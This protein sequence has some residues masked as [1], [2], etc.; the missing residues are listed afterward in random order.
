MKPFT[1]S[2]RFSLSPDR[3][4][5][6]DPAAAELDLES[7]FKIGVSAEYILI[8]D[9]CPIAQI[10]PSEFSKLCKEMFRRNE[11]AMRNGK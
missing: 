10:A 11:E 3:A 8:R 9:D 1:P 4:F 5:K 7:Y 6:K 2:R